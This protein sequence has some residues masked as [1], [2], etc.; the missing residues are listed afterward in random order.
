MDL[1][2]LHNIL[3]KNKYSLLLCVLLVT[4][5]C[6]SV[7]AQ[8]ADTATTVIE[9]VEVPYTDDNDSDKATNYT[10][11]DTPAFRQ[12]PDSVAAKLKKDKA[13][14]YAND[15]SYWAKE[16]VEEDEIPSRG[17]WYHFYDFFSRRGVRIV[18]YILIGL[19][20]LFVIY[21]VIV[22]N[23]L[24]L[25]YF[26][27]KMRKTDDEVITEAEHENIDDSI[28]K[29]I[30]AGNYR[31]GVRFLYIKSLQLLN[32]RGWIR[33]HA[34][35]TNHEYVLQMSSNK[36]AQ[37]FNFLTDVYDYVWYGEFELNNEQFSRVH[38]EFKKFFGAI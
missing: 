37:Q 2:L 10:I 31:A 15:E 3:P 16:K 9:D 11:P 21:R 18:M 25:F 13:F 26:S 7:I 4:G 6:Q 30:E 1:K 8:D 29:A 17:F 5:L 38:G 27:K 32:A 34:Q 12:V 19:V 24:Y 36:H 22:Q 23:N 20:F 14:A 35:A 28:R 33:F